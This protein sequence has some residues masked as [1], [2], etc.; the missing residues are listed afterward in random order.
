MVAME[1]VQPPLT[2]QGRSPIFSFTT[3]HLN[4]LL[5]QAAARLH[6]GYLCTEIIVR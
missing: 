5:T 2:N 4:Q 1:P 3:E 6:L